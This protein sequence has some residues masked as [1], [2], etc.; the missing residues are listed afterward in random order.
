MTTPFNNRSGIFIEGL[1][2]DFP[3]TVLGTSE[4]VGGNLPYA[5]S[6]R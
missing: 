2:D 6:I 4:A 3:A 5:K 1:R